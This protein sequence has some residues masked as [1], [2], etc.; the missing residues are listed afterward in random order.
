M[1]S[2]RSSRTWAALAAAATVALA[3]AACTPSP[4]P[5][6]TPTPEKTVAPSGDGI[7]RIGTLFPTTGAT[8]FLGGA[9]L[10]GVN[11]AIRDINTAGGVLGAPVELVSRDPGDASTQIL[12]T[13]FADLAGRTVDV[14]IG[15]SSS[16]LA[17][18][19]LPL[20]AEARIPLIS[21][22]AT[23]PRLAD[24]D[25][26][27]W[28]FRTIPAYS[29]QGVLLGSLL[30]EKGAKEVAVV[31]TGDELS[32]SLVAGLETTLGE[33]EAELVAHER[34]ASAS[35]VATAVA[36]V[37][38]AAPDAVV[39]ATP[40][41]GE[42][43]RALIV[44]LR[45]AGFGGAKLWLTSQNLADYSQALPAGTLDGVNGILEGVQPDDAFIAKLK[46]EDPGL[47][48][49][50]YAAEAY[51]AVMLAALAA[52]LAGD[53]GG[54]S[55]AWRLVG[56]THVGIRCSS[57]GECLDVLTT[58]PDISYEGVVGPLRFDDAGDPTLGVYGVF[59]YNAGNQYARTGSVNG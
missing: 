45:D 30:P 51:D 10:A 28:F 59:V 39:L 18:R 44:A 41:N 1:S 37:K 16:V 52:T 54:A 12:E 24:V 29:H 50:R 27:G 3:L 36:A 34:A 48:E 58:E 8:T 14:I 57:Y 25:T 38:K 32:E 55:I 23:Y 46:L 11:A 31:T 19:I 40:D 7:F 4:P 5:V 20:A 9:Q 43:T 35:D 42:L 2:A 15:P 53:D 22:A 47:G 21:P 17:E 26:D 6:P 13:S 56:V 49:V 33:N